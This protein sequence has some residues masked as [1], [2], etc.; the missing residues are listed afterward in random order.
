MKKIIQLLLSSLLIIF[1]I[2]FYT[3]YLKEDKQ[4][5]KKKEIKNESLIQNQNNL[6]K[7]LSYE[8]KFDNNAQYLITSELSELVYE[9]DIEIVKMQKF[10]Q[11]SLTK[12]T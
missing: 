8:V 7:N 9:N 6:I 10:L 11:N 4:I 2:F 12:I 5:V 1:S 3:I